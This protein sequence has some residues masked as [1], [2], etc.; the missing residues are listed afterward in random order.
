M[1]A[2]RTVTGYI[3][4][5]APPARRMLRELR[6]AIRSAAP[7]AEEKISY[8]M[9]YYGQGGRVIY[10]AAF[11]KHVS[12]FVMGGAKK[13]YAKELRPYLTSKATLQFP[14]GAPVPLALIRK[15]VRFR[16]KENA[17]AAAAKKKAKKR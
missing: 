3:A 17:E 14:I 5:S 15:L 12:V 11:Q 16:I 1:S 6:A 13:A 4:A 8:G 2:A 7:R 10:F 9:P